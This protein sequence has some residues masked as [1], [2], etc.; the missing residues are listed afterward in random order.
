MGFRCWN[1]RCKKARGR[2]KRGI[3]LDPFYKGDEYQESLVWPLEA[4]L[5]THGVIPTAVVGSRTPILMENPVI[6]G[7]R[8]LPRRDV[9]IKLPRNTCSGR[10]RKMVLHDQ[11]TAEHHAMKSCQQIKICENIIL[12]MVV[13]GIYFTERTRSLCSKSSMEYSEEEPALQCRRQSAR[14]THRH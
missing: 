3:G 11:T 12:S 1:S 8:S 14:R 2:W 10:L 9:P 13:C 7:T 6:G 5:K 4:Y